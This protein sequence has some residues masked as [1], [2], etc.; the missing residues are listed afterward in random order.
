MRSRYL[1]VLSGLGCFFTGALWFTSLPE[2]VP[3]YSYRQRNIDAALGF[4]PMV[5][6]SEDKTKTTDG[7]LRNLEVLE[8]SDYY[9]V[10]DKRRNNVTESGR[11]SE[12][13]KRDSDKVLILM[14]SNY[15]ERHGDDLMNNMI[16][17]GRRWDS[18]CCSGPEVEITLNRSL[19]EKADA[20]VI[21][22]Y[23]KNLDM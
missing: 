2:Y 15:Y 23:F 12:S 8:T 20:I 6:K 14:W 1:V 7:A 22:A 9:G 19:V 18:E 3:V 13:T 10:D 5:H 11:E 17:S 21:F 4:P 16:L